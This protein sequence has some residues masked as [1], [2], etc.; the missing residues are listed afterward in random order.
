M[1]SML[2]AMPLS[3]SPEMTCVPMPR[4]WKFVPVKFAVV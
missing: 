2:K 3:A 1:L 4:I